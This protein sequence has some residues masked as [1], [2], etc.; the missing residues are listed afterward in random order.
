MTNMMTPQ[1]RLHDWQLRLAALVDQ[2]LATPFAWGSHDCCLFAADAVIACT[3]ADL[4]ADLRGSYCSEAEAQAVLASHGG[5]I[6]LAAARLGRSVR[7][8]LAQPGDIGLV[9]IEGRP[10]LALCGGPV[11]L[12]PGPSGLVPLAPDQVLRA[13]RCTAGVA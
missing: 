12:A 7:A 2:R 9:S 10:T 3:G 8:E 11:F 4:A 6:A 13:W 5:L 1:H